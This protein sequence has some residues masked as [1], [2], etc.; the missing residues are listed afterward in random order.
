[1]P[2]PQT[3]TD[4]ALIEQLRGSAAESSAAWERLR[5]RLHESP[6]H[7][8]EP[9]CTLVLESLEDSVAVSVRQ[10][11][12]PAVEAATRDGPVLIRPDLLQRL[13]E[14][15]SGLDTLSVLC[16]AAM[17]VRVDSDGFVTDGIQEV[18]AATE[19]ALLP[20]EDPAQRDVAEYA[21]E[22]AYDL[23]ETVADRDPATLVVV[24]EFWTAAAG[25]DRPASL[26]FAE[27][28]QRAA[29]H[30]PEVRDATL[31]ALEAASRQLPPDSDA[32]AQLGRI[33]EE[34]E[35]LRERARRQALAARI[36]SELRPS[37]VSEAPEADASPPSPESGPDAIRWAE[38][39]LSE[40][41]APAAAAHDRLDPGDADPSPEVIAGAILALDELVAADP[42]DERVGP[43]LDFLCT[44]AERRP[45]LVPHAAL[46]RCTRT[47]GL[48][49]WE[50]AM[51]FASLA[52]VRPATVL[53]RLLPEALGSAV[54]VGGG[55][56]AAIL[57]GI[58]RAEPDLLIAFAR[59]W[60]EQEGWSEEVG[61][62]LAC[63]FEQVAAGSPARS[64][65]MVELLREHTTLPS[66]AVAAPGPPEVARCLERLARIAAG[67]GI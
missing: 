18:L 55:L 1:M 13:L 26:L 52:R 67:D 21:R 2:I 46:E 10:S 28:L 5:E 60:L 20:P 57:S 41:P 44:A 53:G 65:A 27:L 58:G 15:A 11:I 3:V 7:H 37:T 40:D 61:P 34:L 33:R 17:R 54:V 38:N 48:E 64:A 14:R 19:H 4:S 32:A 31:D 49:E 8:A 59:R 51:A 43:L 22:V 50:R 29:R 39:Y 23:W 16:L 25:W 63:A 42:R 35:R 6:E 62:A 66:G 45:D 24:L 12:L 30:R 9:L 56:G 47:E 36:A